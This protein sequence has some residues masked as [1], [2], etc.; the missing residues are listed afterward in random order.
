MD[1]G[2]ISPQWFGGISGISPEL[3]DIDKLNKLADEMFN[4]MAEKMFEDCF[5]SR[6]EFGKN[7]NDE[8]KYGFK[9]KTSRLHT[10]TIKCKWRKNKRLNKKFIKRF[11]Q[12]MIQVPM[13]TAYIVNNEYLICH[14]TTLKRLDRLI[15]K[16]K[17]EGLKL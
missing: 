2:L 11:G 6:P 3:E 16:G 13:D 7:L 12:R 4:S 17:K 8:F 15:N 5:K 14:P 9:V 10:R 1:N